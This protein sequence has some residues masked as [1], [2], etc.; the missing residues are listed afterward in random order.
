MTERPGVSH[1]AGDPGEGSDALTGK[2]AG[3]GEGEPVLAGLG[4]V[5]WSAEDS[6]A[7]EVALEVIQQVVGAYSALIA[8]EE[9]KRA[10]DE[11]RVGSWRGERRR[12]QER[13]RSLAPDDRREVERVSAECAV[14]LRG[15]RA[16][17]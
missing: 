17:R 15:L 14:L 13:G 1:Q 7:Y 2:T 10:P 3:R 4:P 11:S 12:W 16:R 8:K 6:V 5:T 9:R